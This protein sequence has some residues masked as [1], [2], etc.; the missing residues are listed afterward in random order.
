[1]KLKYAWYRYQFKKH[2]FVRIKNLLSPETLNLYKAWLDLSHAPG[3]RSPETGDY[4]GGN[5]DFIASNPLDDA[6]LL[7]YMH[8]VEQ[9]WGIKNMVPSY[10][11]SREYFRGSEL[12]IHRDREA[13]QYSVTLTMCKR[14][15]G[16]TFL[17]FSNEDDKLHAVPVDL[18]EGD[19]IIFNGGSNYTGKWHWRDPLEIDSLVQLF[20][21]YVHPETPHFAD[22][23]FPRPNYRPK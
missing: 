14:G 18:K 7:Q 3:I 21:H 5:I 16:N 10:A 15:K 13:C 1:M 17:W 2:G 9:V 23:S 6:I 22:R 8:L 4:L 19:A 12:K 20:L 11:Y